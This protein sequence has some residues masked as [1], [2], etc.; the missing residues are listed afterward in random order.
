MQGVEIENQSYEAELS[1]LGGLNLH[2]AIC[3]KTIRAYNYC[4]IDRSTVQ[5]VYVTGILILRD[6]EAVLISSNEWLYAERCPKLGEVKASGEL[7][8]VDC[9]RVASIPL[10]RKIFFKEYAY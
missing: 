1:A 4:Q 8:L 5:A 10:P 9:P 3:P 6:S 2:H 7:R